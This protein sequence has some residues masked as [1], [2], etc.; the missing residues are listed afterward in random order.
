MPKILHT[1]DWQMG[2]AFT[3]FETEDGAALVEARFEAIETLARLATENQ[4]DAVLVAG[5]VFDAQT[6]A[7][8]TIR[9]VFNGTQGFAGPWV[10]LP[11][12]HDAALAESVWTRAQRL[13]AVPENVHLALHPGVIDLEPQSLSI[14]C[15]PLTQ[16]HTYSDLTEPFSGY[17]TPEGFLRVGLAHGSVQGL[18]PDEIDSANPIAPNRAEASR[19]D[20]LALGDWHG[21]KQIDERT[22]YSGTPEPERFRNNEAGNALI[23]DVSEPGATATVTP[24]PTGRYQWHQLRET[25]A[26]HSDLEQL[27][28]CLSSLP[29]SAVVDLRLDGSVTLAGEEAL[30]KALSVAEARFRSLRCERSGL[31]LAPTDEDIAALKA[32]GYVGEVVESLRE[33]QEAAQDDVA[34][35]ALAILAGLLREREQ[36]AAQ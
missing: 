16:R 15:A 26:V 19:L 10:M 2:R 27:L 11:G 5:D 24:V 31:Q 29:E 14:L 23:V 7:D 20:Y 18:L 28:E 6:V 34:R 25:L 21:T 30:L 36:E 8:R 3:R 1:A 4:C 12:N 33:R 32:D 13:G 35:D 22:W 9:R 17:Q